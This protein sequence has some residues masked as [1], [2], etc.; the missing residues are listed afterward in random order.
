[1]R[2]VQG[3]GRAQH[4]DGDR[5]GPGAATEEEVR[6]AERLEGH[7]MR[8]AAALSVLLRLLGEDFVT[9]YRFHPGRRW[10]FDV[11]NPK[12]MV[13]IEINGGVWNYGRHV[14][15]GGFT[16]DMEKINA[17]MMLGWSVLQYEWRTVETNPGRV[18][19]E[20]TQTTEAKQTGGT[21]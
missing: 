20:V 4:G 17:A 16:G 11:A 15:G 1:M 12:T 18:V 8:R 5:E 3:K 21:K 19:A 14:R 6:K 2:G 7:K 9:E 13:A 10:R